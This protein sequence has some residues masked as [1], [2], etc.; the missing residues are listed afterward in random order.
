MREQDMMS[1]GAAEHY[2][3]AC[4]VI[5]AAYNSAQTI[6]DAIDSV[7]A[8]TRADFEVIVV[9]DGSTDET[10][11]RVQRYAHDPRVR[12]HRQDNAGPSAARNAGIA[13]ARGRYLGM[14]DSDDMWLPGYIERAVSALERHPEAGLVF[15]DAWIL[16]QASG[17][18]RNGT[19]L[20]RRHMP[21]HYIESEAALK[22]LV[23]F[24]FCAS[25]M[26]PRQ[27]LDYVGGHNLRLAQAEDYELCLRIIARGYGAVPIGPLAIFRDRV[28]SLSKDTL[29]LVV[30]LRD[31]YRVFLAD[32]PLSADV[33]AAAHKRL[34][35]VESNLRRLRE[36][37]SFRLVAFQFRSVL[38]RIARFLYR[39]RGLLD[40]PPPEIAAAFPQLGHG[41]RIVRHGTP[42]RERE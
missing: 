21:E 13:L 36:P 32:Q 26:I 4:S 27:V 10:P 23:Q 19:E 30:G 29:S 1:T 28:D 42:N 25:V 12:L 20:S 15:A 24:N 9:D 7:L 2:S 6:D 35:E 17:R 5:I 40:A 18:F 39:R 3:P 37:S 31:A 14:L 8:Q 34:D 38:A 16:E 11:S 41:S 22:L 33:K